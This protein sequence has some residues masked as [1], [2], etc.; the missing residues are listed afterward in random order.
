M[1]LSNGDFLEV[2]EFFVLRDR[3]CVTESYRYQWMDN[4]QK[5][6]RKRWDNVEHFPDLPNF[7]HH[8]HV[9][10]ESNVE[11]SKSLSILDL[12]DI[13]EAEIVS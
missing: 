9:G 12:I 1:T 8:V 4:S 2:V 7:P 10:E 11:A 3:T 13:I 5:V 6:L